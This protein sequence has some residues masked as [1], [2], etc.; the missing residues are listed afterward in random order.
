MG[1]YN[2][3]R[4]DYVDGVSQFRLFKN[5][6]AV[7]ELRYGEES[8]RE[9]ERID[10]NIERHV[11][12]PFGDF[13]DLKG[14]HIYYDALEKALRHQRCV[15]SSVNRTKNMVYNYARG[16]VWEWFVT[17][18]FDKRKID[19]YDYSLCCKSVR[20]WLKNMRNRY[21]KELKYLVVPE[22]HKD[23]AWHFHAL[24]SNTGDM[25][26]S[27]AFNRHTGELL[28][29][30]KGLQIYNLGN[31]KWGFS[32]ATLVESTEKASS[33]VTKYI[34]KEMAA[35]TKG[36]RRCYPSNNLDK[37][38]R[39]YFFYE[40][41][42]KVIFFK[43]YADKIIYRKDVKVKCGSYENEVNYIEIDWGLAN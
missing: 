15:V 25:L 8:V 28:H 10:R 30:K 36:V 26:F 6:V 24:M 9:S 29:T 14:E 5:P 16:N 4:Y 3:V 27:K 39:S 7:T 33:Y 17:L 43:E 11:R 40:N 2:L 1:A 41:E 18:T 20:E 23:G 21:C 19:R 32:T 35:R 22:M 31:Y 13:A 38:K 42:E 34:T 12:T 37:P